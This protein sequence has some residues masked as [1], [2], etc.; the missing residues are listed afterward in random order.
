[1]S[2]NL[3]KPLEEKYYKSN[4]DILKKQMPILEEKNIINNLLKEDLRTLAIKLANIHHYSNQ[5]V[6]KNREDFAGHK[7]FSGRSIKF[8]INLLKTEQDNINKGIIKVIQD[9]YCYPY[10]KRPNNLKENLIDKF[11]EAPSNELMQF[12][13]NDEVE[14]KEKYKTIIKDLNDIIENPNISFDMNQFIITTFAYVYKDIPKLIEEIEKCLMSIN[15]ENINYTYLSL[16]K[17]IIMNY[18]ERGGNNGDISKKLRKKNIND[19]V[20]SKEDKYLKIPQNLL[21]IYQALLEKKLITK[22]SFIDYINYLSCFDE[23]EERLKEENNDD[24]NESPLAKISKNEKKFIREK[25]LKGKKPFIELCLNNSNLVGNLATLSIAYPELNKKSK[26]DLEKLFNNLEE[27]DKNLFIL[28]I[29]LFNNSEFNGDKDEIIICE[30]FYEFLKR[31]EFIDAVE[32]TYKDDELLKDTNPDKDKKFIEQCKNIKKELND[33][34]KKELV[35]CLNEK[36]KE[37]VQSILSKWSQNYEQYLKD[38]EKAY[39]QKIGREKQYQI[40]QKIKALIEKLLKKKGK[41]NDDFAKGLLDDMKEHLESIKNYDE[42]SYALAEIDVNNFLRD[43]ESYIDSSAKT[44]YIHFP[45]IEYESEY[46]PIGNFQEVYT[47]LMEFSDCKILLNEFKINEDKRTSM[48]FGRLKKLLNIQKGSIMEIQYNILYDKIMNHSDEMKDYIQNFEEL[49]LS[50]LL[51]NIYKIDKKYLKNNLII[52]KLNEYCYRNRLD[53]QKNK[54]DLEWASF[55]SQKRDPFDEIVFPKY[56]SASIIKLFSLKNKKNE[57]DE[58]IFSLGLINNNIKEFYKRV[59]ALLLN[60][61]MN[62]IN[63]IKLIFIIVMETIFNDKENIKNLVEEI[64]KIFKEKFLEKEEIEKKEIKNLIDEIKVKMKRDVCV[65]YQNLLDF[66]ADLFEYFQ[67]SEKNMIEDKEININNISDVISINESLNSELKNCLN[68]S[69]YSNIKYIPENEKKLLMEDIFFIKDDKWKNNIKPEYKKYPSLLYFLLKYP[70]CEEEL[71]QFLKK[72]DSIRKNDYNKFP[73][74]LLIFRIFSHLN[75]LK[76]EMRADNFLG[77]L[78]QKEII[79]QFKSKSF[80]EFKKTPDMNWIGLLINNPNVNKIISPKMN[81]IYNYLENLC[82]YSFNPSEENKDVCKKLIQ[83]MIKSLFKIIFEGKLDSL[84]SNEIPKIDDEDYLINEEKEIND[85]LYFTKLPKIINTFIKENLEQKKNFFEQ[86]KE[87][88]KLING[89]YLENQNLY[90]DFIKTIESDIKE[91]KTKRINS[92]YEIQKNSKTSECEE[93]KNKCT[94]YSKTMKILNDLNTSL[95]DYN[96]HIKKVLDAKDYLKNISPKYFTT[97]ISHCYIRITFR[98]EC[99]KG[100]LKFGD[101]SQEISDIKIDS[102]YYINSKKVGN[103]NITVTTVLNNNIE[104]IKLYKNEYKLYDINTE[105][106]NQEFEKAQKDIEL[107]EKEKPENIKITFTINENH[108]INSDNLKNDKSFQTLGRIFNENG[109]KKILKKSIDMINKKEFEINE[110]ESIIKEF[111]II[112]NDIKDLEFQTP[113]FENGREPP[114][115]TIDFCE[116]YKNEF[117]DKILPKL[118]SLIKTFDDFDNLRQKGKNIEL[119]NDSFSTNI[120]EKKRP[121]TEELKIDKSKKFTINYPYLTLLTDIEIPKLKFGYSS[122]NLTIGPII[123]SLYQGTKFTYNIISFVDKNLNCKLIFD[124]EKI[125]EDSK[126]LIPLIT[127]KS[128]VSPLEPISIYFKVPFPTKRK[129]FNLNGHLEIKIDNSE[130]EPVSID[131]NF[132]V[133]LLPLEIYIISENYGVSF[134]ENKLYL[135]NDIFKENE[136][137]NFKYIIRNFHEDFSILGYD[138]SLENLNKNEVENKPIVAKDKNNLHINIPY[139]SKKE[140]V[141]NDLLKVYFTNKLNIPLELDGK[142]NK[143]RFRVFYYNRIKNIIEEDNANIYVYNHIYKQIYKQKDFEIEM[144]FAIK[145]LENE[146]HKFGIEFP[147]FKNPIFYL[148]K[149]NQISNSPEIEINSSLIYIKVLVTFCSYYSD[150]S[151]YG[152]INFYVDGQKK[153]INFKI[154]KE[155]KINTNNENDKFFKFPYKTLIN[156]KYQLIEKSLISNPPN[157]FTVCYSPYCVKFYKKVPDT[158]AKPG[159]INCKHSLEVCNLIAFL[160]VFN[161]YWVPNEDYFGDDTC[162]EFKKLEEKKEN[163]EDAKNNISNIINEIIKSKSFSLNPINWI[164]NYTYDNIKMKKKNELIKYGNFICFIHWLI[165]DYSKFDNKIEYLIEISKKIGNEAKYLLNYLSS[166]KNYYEKGNQL[167]KK[168]SEEEESHKLINDIPNKKKELYPIIYHN[169]II[170]LREIMKI[171]YNFLEMKKFNISKIF[172]AEEKKKYKRNIKKCFPPYNQ[173]QFEKMIFEIIKQKNEENEENII[174]P[175]LSKAWLFDEFDKIPELVDLNTIIENDDFSKDY[176]N[177]EGKKLDLNLDILKIKDLSS[178]NSLDKIISVLNNGLTISQAFIFFIGKLNKNKVNEIFNYLYEIYHKTKDSTES[179]LSSEIKSFKNS[180][181]NLCRSLK[182]SEVDL[183]K[184]EDVSNL[185]KKIDNN[186]FLNEIRP[187]PIPYTLPKESKSNNFNKNYTSNEKKNVEINIVNNRK[188][189]NKE[190]ININNNKKEIEIK[191]IKNEIPKEEKKIEFNNKENKNNEPLNNED[192][193]I[194]EKDELKKLEKIFYKRKETL[195]EETADK[196]NKLKSISDED[197]TNRIIELMLKKKRDSNLKMPDSFPEFKSDFFGSREE[198]LKKTLNR[199]EGEEIINLPLYILLN[200][201]T[202]NLYIKFIQH[203]INFDKKEICAVIALDLCRTIDKKFKLF[204]TLIATAMANYFNGIEIPYSIVVFCDYGVQFVIKDFEEPHHEDISQLIF[205]AIMVPRFSTR[206]AN[207]CYFISQKVNCKDRPNKKIFIISNGLD[208]KLKIGEKWAPIFRNIKEQFC[209]YFV[210][211]NFKSNLEEKEIIKIWKDFREKTKVELVIICQEDILNSNSNIYSPFKDIMQS[212]SNKNNNSAKKIKISQPEFKEVVEFEK[213]D[214]IRLIQSINEEI[215]NEKDYF[216]QNRIH[217]ASKGK[218]ILEDIKVQNPFLVSKSKCCDEEE[219]NFEKIDVDVKSALE[220]LFSNSIA[221]EMKLEYI[222]FIFTPNKPSMFSPS[223]KG[224]RLY[225]MGLINFCITHG[226]DNKIWLEKNKGLKKDYRVSI[227]ID[228]SISCFNS[229]MRPHSI[230]TVLAML[231]MLSLVEIPFFDLIIATP[232]NPVVLSCG[233]DTINVLNFKSNLWNILLEQLTFNEEGCNL[234]DCLKLIYKLKSVNNVKKY[235]TFVLTDGMFD[236][237][238]SEDLQDYISFCEE[239]FI[240]IYGIGLGYY[241]E[242]IK[243]LFNKCLFCLNPFMIVKVLSVFFGSGVKF[244]ETL[245]LISFESYNLKNVLEKFKDILNKLNS[246]QEYKILYGFLDGLPLLIESLD[247]IT[248]PDLADEISNSNPEIT[249]S[250]TMCHKGEF[251]G[252]KILIGQFWNCKLSS[253]ESEWVDKKYLLE[254]YDKNK[255]CLKE[256]LNYYSIEIVIKEDYKECIKELQTGNYYAHWIICSDNTGKLPNG[257]NPNLIGQYIDALKIFWI[258]GGS[259]VFWNDNE[260]FNTECNLFL[261]QAEFPGDISKTKVRFGGN[262]AGKKIMKPGDINTGIQEQSEFGKFNNKRLFNDGKYPTFSLGHNLIKIAEGTTISYVQDQDNISPFNIF[263]YEHQG[264][265]NILFYTP[266]F[267]YSHGYITIDGGFTKLFNELDSDGTKRYILNIA[268]FTTQFSKRFGEIGE[269]WKTD[270]KLPP[271]NFIIKENEKWE[272]FNSRGITNDFDIIYLIDATGSMGKYLAA[273]RDQCI[274]ISE[275]LKRELPQ[276]DFNFGAVFYKD[277]VDCPGEKNHVYCLKRDVSLLKEEISKEI[278]DG[279]GD[280]PEDWVGGYDM[281][282]DNIAWRNGTRLIIHIADAPAHGSE[283][284]NKENHE[285][286]NP[287]LYTRIQKCVDKNIKIIGFQIGNYPKPSFSKF[288]KEYKSRGGILYKI[289][290]FNNK[291]NANEIS[292]HFKDMVI[293]SA[294]AAAPE[295]K[296]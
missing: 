148:L 8:I 147:N 94:E 113:K 97:K 108:Q 209:F 264:G 292:Q 234:L 69:R 81:Y 274:N 167:E 158:N 229:Y 112:F 185:Q 35:C 124:K 135:K 12:L 188:N 277:P 270:F 56:T 223:T 170:L 4:E 193:D 152:K 263:G 33:L 150:F 75:C 92:N 282:L 258:N 286:E 246:F 128:K 244:I 240:E 125:D 238:E 25:K 256:V 221:S 28:F 134:K 207:A 205:D 65:S 89:I 267:K 273:A 54:K 172:R 180:F 84:F 3:Y 106:K 281:A 139:I 227:I 98:N 64:Q 36:E 269:N 208:P 212:E 280:S 199:K 107:L 39:Y 220:K 275:Q 283:W 60:K 67:Y 131:F 252:F 45:I 243:K 160:T 192:S 53:D 22:I 157:Y 62:I 17:I 99:M 116:K 202:K 178:A 101:V 254:R 239:S 43:I 133:I 248:N 57:D 83:N 11:I 26:E 93:K 284:C 200:D 59:N 183:S 114:T 91:E 163:I 211:P 144:N 216:I 109:L 20:L 77:Q 7:T 130:I 38:L 137:I 272:G 217:I 203:S 265:I 179:I 184:F 213:S 30:K 46:K 232:S 164:Y 296:K 231:R 237:K 44:I 48:N 117:K 259:L 186:I 293:E 291:M 132:N 142:I 141:L 262:H 289:Y 276:F 146:K 79:S 19:L 235:Y 195:V 121:R 138:F 214:F 82:N 88:I 233:N 100:T 13:R 159:E 226:Q 102:D 201:L 168:L 225:L 165:S 176:E 73:T 120:F 126:K 95:E 245:P 6:D 23:N 14:D 90:V 51:L 161:N 123:A 115:P 76:I 260:P 268:A 104:E 129:K 162:D 287:K 219:Y 9:I 166:K 230:R 204:H 47:L 40:K 31:N 24:R 253:L 27:F 15:I 181:E 140:E 215:G 173:E 78:I 86:F 18:K 29:K 16:F 295:I 255:E 151:R 249:N 61:D 127:I 118:Q 87:E 257:G 190:N 187:N 50:N 32:K 34:S 278:A 242:G 68:E 285:S 145:F 266:P 49:T 1:M 55:L 143:V 66:I 261:E 21:F 52:E 154:N 41:I 105:Y 153:E 228:S 103:N 247:E 122:Y 80:D 155:E 37:I 290:K 182:A 136:I 197:V 110:I 218:Y 250:N 222:E 5:L 71:R 241:P 279:G 251:E 206:I 271:F 58:G 169:I 111:R 96:E 294:H 2:N 189:A 196:I 70:N 210:K 10:K 191:I 156:E 194:E 236:Q 63:T 224:T 74:F 85:T 171:R 72:T 288:E 177:A 149:D 175:K 198:I 174:R 42:E 119:F